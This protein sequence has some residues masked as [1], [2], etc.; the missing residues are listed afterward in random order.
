MVATIAQSALILLLLTSSLILCA[1]LKIRSRTPVQQPPEAPDKPCDVSNCH[2]SKDLDRQ[3]PSGLAVTAASSS[4]IDKVIDER[5]CVESI[6]M[7]FLNDQKDQNAISELPSMVPFPPSTNN[8]WLRRY[9]RDRNVQISA[10][11]VS[12]MEL[13]RTISLRVSDP[14]IQSGRI[15]ALTLSNCPNTGCG[16]CGSVAYPNYTNT[17]RTNIL[18]VSNSSYTGKLLVLSDPSL[19]KASYKESLAGCNTEILFANRNSRVAVNNLSCSETESTHSDTVR[20]LMNRNLTSQVTNI[21]M[22][23]GEKSG[24]ENAD[25]K[26]DNVVRESDLIRKRFQ[27]PNIQSKNNVKDSSDDCRP[28]EKESDD[29]YTNKNS[30]SDDNTESLSERQSITPRQS[31]RDVSSPIAV[32]TRSKGDSRITQS[33]LSLAVQQIP[34]MPLPQVETPTTVAGVQQEARLMKSA[35]NIDN[36][37]ELKVNAD[38]SITHEHKMT[39][40]CLKKEIQPQTIAISCNSQTLKTNTESTEHQSGIVT[41]SP[42][43]FV[44]ETMVNNKIPLGIQNETKQSETVKEVRSVIVGRPMVSSLSRSKSKSK[45]SNRETNSR[46]ENSQIVATS[47]SFPSEFFAAGQSRPHTS[48]AVLYTNKSFSSTVVPIPRVST[49]APTRRKRRTKRRPELAE[50]SVHRTDHSSKCLPER[51]VDISH[52]SCEPQTY[53]AYDVEPLNTDSQQGHSWSLSNLTRQHQPEL[54]QVENHECLQ[55][56]D[57]SHYWPPEYQQVYVG[58]LPREQPYILL[59]HQEPAQ[60]SH[61]VLQHQRLPAVPE[62]LNLHL[63]HPDDHMAATHEGN[64][65]CDDDKKLQRLEKKGRNKKR[66]ED[67]G[68]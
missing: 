65:K 11:P 27:L 13:E 2:L 33:S 28:A 17:M 64:N 59:H 40:C 47:S 60:C 48:D 41:S 34:N 43:L 9:P 12:S 1:K 51:S 38:S 57:N 4:S 6:N 10:S 8:N 46:E 31:H 62:V 24:T 35:N 44:T 7:G 19:S 49:S 54:Y 32:S 68:Q 63:H 22:P 30:M 23:L 58:R 26:Y 36:E 45:Y 55:P 53:L 29:D 67:P 25:K 21:R 39:Q 18:A 3:T 15:G 50:V 66:R 20:T 16:H 56:C 14:P 5:N 52:S 61:G 42:S 37:K